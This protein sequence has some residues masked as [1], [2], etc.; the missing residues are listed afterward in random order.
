[1]TNITDPPNDLN[2][3]AGINLNNTLKR[4]CMINRE[5][6]VTLITKR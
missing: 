4:I 6:V 2:F 1:M 3:K 5:D